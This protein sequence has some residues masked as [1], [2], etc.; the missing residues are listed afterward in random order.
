MNYLFKKYQ[1][2]ARNSRKA[3]ADAYNHF[4][5]HSTEDNNKKK[6]FS[7]VKSKRT[8][9][10]GV[11]PLKNN[12]TTYTKDADI[13]RILNEQFTSVFSDDNGS[14]PTS[15]GQPA[16]T[17]TSEHHHQRPNCYQEWSYQAPKQT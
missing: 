14:I 2:A 12:G 4:I 3:C 16:N 17:I 10:T 15:L 1:Q 5:H 13:A 8:E 9:I 7:I 6:L 11:A